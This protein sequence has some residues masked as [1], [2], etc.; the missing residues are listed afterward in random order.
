ML[1]NKVIMIQAVGIAI[2]FIAVFG[3]KANTKANTNAFQ[4]E[5]KDVNPSSSMTPVSSI[6]SVNQVTPF[7]IAGS[8]ENIKN[9]SMII[10]ADN[11][12]KFDNSLDEFIGKL[13]GNLYTAIKSDE[14]NGRVDYPGITLD[15]VTQSVNNAKKY[16]QTEDAWK[17]TANELTTK[18]TFLTLQKDFGSFRIFTYQPDYVFGTGGT[19]SWSFAQYKDSDGKINLLMEHLA[20]SMKI[21]FFIMIDCWCSLAM[22]IQGGQVTR[23]VDIYIKMENGK[24]KNWWRTSR[25]VHFK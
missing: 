8:E 21:H 18:N 11:S 2:V 7:S 14:K 22:V 12:T 23:F 6:L 17:V 10:S 24:M 3:T 13:E 1:K 16:L 20:I 19:N 5:S 4:I 15:L 9:S 25:T